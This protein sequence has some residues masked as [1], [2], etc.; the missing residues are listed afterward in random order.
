MWYCEVGV[1]WRSC[2]WRQALAVEVGGGALTHNE[3][4]GSGVR[5]QTHMMGMRGVE[6]QAWTWWMKVVH[7]SDQSRPSS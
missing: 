1:F 4:R 5:P 6:A 3:Q 2:A 7:K